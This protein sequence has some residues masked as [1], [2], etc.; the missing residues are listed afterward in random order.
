MALTSRPAISGRAPAAGPIDTLRAAMRS[1][2][3]GLLLV[4]LPLQFVWAS[5]ASYCQHEADVVVDH[6]GHHE[7]QHVASDSNDTQDSEPATSETGLGA[8]DNDCGYCHL[9]CAQPLTAS[10]ASWSDFTV[11]KLV[12][13]ASVRYA[14]REPEGLERPNWLGLARSASLEEPRIS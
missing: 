9:S 12:S 2:V 8:V 6:I 13:N 5:V 7:H 10:V 11:H 1:W 14:T 3:L 4:L